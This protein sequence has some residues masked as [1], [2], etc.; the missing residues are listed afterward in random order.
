MNTIL[1]RGATKKQM[2]EQDVIFD[3]NEDVV[4]AESE[5][6]QEQD[7]SSLP[8]LASNGDVNLWVDE[9]KNGNK[10]LKIDAPF[11]GSEP[12]FLMDELKPGFNQLVEKWEESRE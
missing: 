11:L 2:T 4:S 5:E 6:N 10:F 3:D 1:P 12:V 7:E 9:D 8:P